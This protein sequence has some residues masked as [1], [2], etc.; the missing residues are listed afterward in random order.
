ML[1]LGPDLVLI[2]QGN[3]SPDV[4]TQLIAAKVTIQVFK[5]P[6]TVLGAKTLVTEIASFFEEP[7]KGE[8]IISKIDA[9][10]AQLNNYLESQ[11]IKPNAVFVM[12]RGP[13][14]VFVAGDFRSAA[15]K[16]FVANSSPSC[17]DFP[18]GR[19]GI[20]DRRRITPGHV[21]NS[22]V[23]PGLIVITYESALFAVIFM[24]L[25]PIRDFSTIKDAISIYI[26][27]YNGPD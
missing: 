4:V 8:E 6:T 27:I 18:F 19:R 14:T 24:V 7:E 20:G 11:V 26:C 9:D 25:I 17:P 3:L 16:C 2:E 21:Q 23:E 5:K 10:I 15:T 12:A 13:E 1:A 22:L